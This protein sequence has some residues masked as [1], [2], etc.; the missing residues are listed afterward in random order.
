M[1]QRLD[2]ILDKLNSLESGQVELN[3]KLEVMESGQI[4]LNKKLEVMESGQVELNNKL[5]AMESGQIEL[6]KK[7]EVMESGQDELY[8]MVRA[9][10]DRQEETDAKLDALS[11]DVHHAHGEIAGVKD[12]VKEL[13]EGVIFVNRKVADTEYEVNLLKQRKQ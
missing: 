3:K 11:M 7:L 10:R 8:Q 2:I 6:N 4:E 5:E 9:I 12:A 13:R 1:D